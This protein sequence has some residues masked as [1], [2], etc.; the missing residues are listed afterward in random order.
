MTSYLPCLSPTQ[1]DTAVLLPPDVSFR[2]RLNDLT[3][4]NAVIEFVSDSS[5]PYDQRQ[6]DN[7][8]R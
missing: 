2:Y 7:E 8:L 3:F 1:D 5:H 4:V 6:S